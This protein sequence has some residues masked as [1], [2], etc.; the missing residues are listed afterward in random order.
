MIIVGV[1]TTLDSM[2]FSVACIGLVVFKK[3]R[4]Q[5]V[6]SYPALMCEKEKKSHPRVSMWSC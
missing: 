1:Y 3:R 5:R 4:Y 6:E 2:N